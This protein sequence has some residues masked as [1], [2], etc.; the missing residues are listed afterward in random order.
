M[1][2]F[3]ITGLGKSG[4]TFLAH[5]LNTSPTWTVSHEPGGIHEAK[6]VADR[7]R[8]NYGEVSHF[9][10]RWA[11]DLDC[12]KAVILRDPLECVASRLSI[13]DPVDPGYFERRLTKLG[14]LLDAG[15]Q[16]IRFDKF[17]DRNYLELT[18]LRL[19]ITDADFSDITPKGGTR[20][21]RPLTA[22]EL[23]QYKPAADRFKRRYEV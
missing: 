14:E 10:Y 1:R 20:F 13:G 22:D 18:A 2:S 6:N 4:T 16:P 15:A 7:L 8:P 19:G 3:I 17:S 11:A 21:K 9:L 5:L 23:K 12:H